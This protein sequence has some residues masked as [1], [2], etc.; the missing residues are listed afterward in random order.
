VFAVGR[1][2][3]LGLNLY[4]GCGGEGEAVAD[5]G[6]ALRWGCEWWRLRVNGCGVTWFYG[7]VG[8]F[9][10][11]LLESAVFRCFGLGRAS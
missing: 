6:V 4:A 9:A 11:G 8:D 5:V 1:A 3:E 10:D 7:G 2:V